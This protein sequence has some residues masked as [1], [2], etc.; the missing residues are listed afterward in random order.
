MKVFYVYTHTA[1][2]TNTV[3]YV[4][5]GTN[6][7]YKYYYRSKNKSKRS[8]EWKEFVK[9]INYNYKI[10]ILIESDNCEFIREKER[11]FIKLYGRIDIGTG[12]LVNK[13]NGRGKKRIL[14]DKAHNNMVTKQRCKKVAVYNING[15]KFKVFDRAS[16]AAEEL[17]VSYGSIRHCL[18]GRIKQSQ[19]LRFIFEKFSKDKIEPLTDYMIGRVFNSIK[20]TNLIDG[21]IIYYNSIT[22]ASNLT[23][24]P[25]GTIANNLTGVTS[26]NRHNLKFEYSTIDLK[27]KIII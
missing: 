3:F 13:D 12:S 22:E 2:E 21:T 17:N 5:M 11:E 24:I 7:K 23:K 27:K 26:K 9:N 19:G 4:G 14:S 6:N 20:S 16:K 8:D 15:D 1:I 10:D 25:I 18:K